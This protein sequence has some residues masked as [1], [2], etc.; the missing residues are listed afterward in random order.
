[1]L[2]PVSL[3]LNARPLL[4]L[5]NALPQLA[6]Q[7]NVLARLFLPALVLNDLVQLQ[8]VLVLYARLLLQLVSALP[9]LALQLNALVR[10]FLPALLRM[11][12][13]YQL[14]LVFYLTCQNRATT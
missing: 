12:V 10:L 8:F 2:A 14:L 7:L 1:M 3:A 4:Q 9:Q 13:V 11:L 6:L 5:V